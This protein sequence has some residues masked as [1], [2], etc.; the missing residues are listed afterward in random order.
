MSQFY[1]GSASWNMGAI[2]DGN[3][4]TTDITV[5]GA[6]LGDFVQVSSSADVADLTLVGAVTAA[7]TV[8]VQL[9]NWTGASIDH[10]TV[11]IY[12]M[13]TKRLAMVDA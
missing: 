6:A 1:E 10:G 8:T 13:V 4:A 5:T 3:E 2:A 9:G 11:T 7:N 12:V